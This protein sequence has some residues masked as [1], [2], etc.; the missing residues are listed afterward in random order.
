MKEPNTPTA[1]A[2]QKRAQFNITWQDVSCGWDSRPLRRNR[3]PITGLSRYA[4][5]EKAEAQVAIW[6]LYFP[7]NRYSIEE[8]AS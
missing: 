3:E 4:T 1:S 6:S 5:R 8:I 7:F 2:S